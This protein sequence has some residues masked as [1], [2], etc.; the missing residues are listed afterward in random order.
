MWKPQRNGVGGLIINDRRCEME[1]QKLFGCL[2]ATMLLLGNSY[3]YGQHKQFLWGT[4]NPS[5]SLY[6]YYVMAAK[7]VN[8][9]VPEYNI[10]VSASETVKN[11]K[12]LRRGDF[13]LATIAGAAAYDSYHGEGQFK[14]EPS[15]DL[16]LIYYWVI[17]PTN[18]F[19]ARDSGVST[20]QG[21]E[22]KNFSP[23]GHGMVTE[24][25]VMNLCEL[26]RVKPKYYRGSLPDLVE[27][28]N[29]GR[30]IGFAKSGLGN[31]PDASIMDVQS[32]R[33]LK[34]LSLP[35][36]LVEQ[37]VKKYPGFVRAVVKA[38]TYRDQDVDCVLIGNIAGVGGRKQLP[39]EFVYKM[40]KTLWDNREALRKAFPPAKDYDFPSLTLQWGTL[41]LHKGAIKFYREID[42]KIPDHLIPPEE[43][44]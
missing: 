17:N 39:E 43:K 27:S 32:N 1:K 29:M 30:I 34:F 26:A 15:P 10:V 41:P 25:E 20:L 22:G 33:P 37:Y 21:L 18:L 28:M 12:T 44:S 14:N 13:D 31:F 9:K 19:V 42:M 3:A 23:G 24:K 7:F 6:T 11:L 5:S 4:A 40:L 16:R 8:E 35:E 36:S 38:K 2:I